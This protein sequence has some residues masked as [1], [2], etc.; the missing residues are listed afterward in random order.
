MKTVDKLAHKYALNINQIR[1][2]VKTKNLDFKNLNK[3]FYD[4]IEKNDVKIKQSQ[5]ELKKVKDISLKEFIYTNREIPDRWKKKVD[6]EDDLLNLMV[7]DNNILTYIGTCPKEEVNKTK[8]YSD[9]KDSFLNS[10][11]TFS[12]ENEKNFPS[13]NDRYITKSVF[14]KK[15][16]RLEDKIDNKNILESE[17]SK[18]NT[19][20]EE[21]I[22]DNS[23]SK[24]S[25][26]KSKSKIKAQLTDKAIN[27]I[28]EDFKTAYPIKEKL[29]NLYT[30]TNYYNSNKSSNLLD[31]SD[32]TNLP[33]TL[34]SLRNINT[35]SYNTL[36]NNGRNSFF[37]SIKNQQLFK[38]KTVFRQNVFN[39]L[40][41]RNTYSVGKKPPTKKKLKFEINDKARPFFGSDYQS[42]IKKIEIN[43]P[44]INKNLESINYYGPFFSHCPPC[45]NRNMEY[46][47]NLEINQCLGIIHHIKKIRTKNSILDIKKS[48][49]T[50][51]NKPQIEKDI[52]L[53]TQSL[54][55]NE[56][57]EDLDQ[58]K[59]TYHNS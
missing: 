40:V 52:I 45:Y 31:G 27:N 59:N 32:T 34:N 18:R 11:K 2:P 46:Y 49:N 3:G 55:S 15:S 9:M 25:R 39:N 6:Y 36:N 37:N 50:E 24:M 19:I 58:M 41:S 12:K 33:E 28:L 7:K 14:E 16:P 22:N 57:D 1:G 5:K 26:L 30:T 44:I 43:N 56:N 4:D 51:Q 13:I 10:K 17:R 47:K 53:D 23:L 38:R 8:T 29:H 21:F 48:A 42:F 20:T 54:Q 35:H